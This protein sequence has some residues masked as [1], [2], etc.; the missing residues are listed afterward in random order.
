MVRNAVRALY[1]TLT[2]GFRV[3]G[4]ENIPR[5]GAIIVAPNHAS[6][7]D[8]PAVGSALPRVLTYMAKEEL[9]RFK[10][11]GWLLRTVGAFPVRRG[12]GDMESIKIAMRILERGDALLVFPEGTRNFGDRMVSMNRGVEMLARK[13]GAL[14]VPTAIVGT[15]TK[16]GKK[17]KLRFWGRVSVA[18]GEPVSHSELG[19][20]SAFTSALE[21]RILAL[22]AQNGYPLR[23]ASE[24]Q[25]TT[26]T[27]PNDGSSADS[28][29]ASA[30][31]PS[32]R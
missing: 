3:V 19:S 26:T 17:K 9:F 11:L 12:A 18:F 15:S 2:G 25:E 23:T 14:V 16:W 21:A 27:V 6:Y 10:F 5:S 29:S 1:F 22:C 13:T 7:L 32:P 31:T 8:P 24:T 4:K 30:D 28:H 20:G